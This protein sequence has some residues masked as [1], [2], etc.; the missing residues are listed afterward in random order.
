MKKSILIIAAFVALAMLASCQKEQF[1]ANVTPV[2]GV[3]E[4]T[5]T[6]E[7]PTK[8]AID[9]EGKVSWKA[10]DEIT[11]TDA[12]SNSAVYVAGADGAST[13]FTLKTGETAVG[14]GPYTATYGDI[15]NQIYSAEGANYPLAA[16]ATSTTAF[17][18]SSSYAVVKITAKSEGDEV[19]ESVDVNYGENVYAL[20]CGDGVTL[21][22][23]G[24]DFFVAVETATEAAALSVTF[25][26]ADKTAT[27][28]RTSAVTLA[29]K[30]L[31][32]V[33]LTFAEGDWESPEADTPEPLKGVFTVSDSDTPDDP[34]DD[35]KVSFSQGNLRYV[36][37]TKKWGFYEHQYDFC[38]TV[39]YTGHHSDTV[40]LFTWGYNA[41]QSILPDGAANNNVSRTSGDLEQTEDWGSQIGDGNTWRTLSAAEWMYLSS[42]RGASTVS[43][44]SNARYATA[45]VNGI[46]G[47]ILLPDIY[48]HP[49]EV[50]A[51]S[52]INT[53]SAAFTDNTYD[54]TAWKAMESAGAVF[55]PA[56]GLRGTKNIINDYGIWGFYWSSSAENGD[57]AYRGVNFGSNNYV[58]F[59]TA[60]QYSTRGSGLSVR[61]VT[62]VSAPEP[63]EPEEP[64]EI[65]ITRGK[66]GERAY[67][68]IGKVKWATQNLAI[69]ES[70]NMKW[71]GARTGEN[72]EA[73]KV[74]GTDEDVIVGDY[75]QWAAYAGYC[76]SEDGSDKGLLIYNSFTHDCCVGGDTKREFS[77]KAVNSNDWPPFYFFETKK[78]DSG[79]T[80]K[81]KSPYYIMG[82]GYQKYNN[83]PADSYADNKTVLDSDDDV[84]NILWGNTWRMPTN[85]EFQSLY[86]ATFWAWDATDMGYY[87]FLPA[88]ADQIK[89]GASGTIGSLDKSKA[90]LF[91]PCSGSGSNT[92]LSDNGYYWH[93]TLHD[94][95]NAK[96]MSLNSIRVEF[97]SL[98]RYCGCSVRPVSN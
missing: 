88:D 14:E 49:S 53:P 21:T 66:I 10:G 9:A 71:K 2:A 82:T 86:N 91:F 87:V 23:D 35:V 92:T 37:K 11:V 67:I 77:F 81:G 36:V 96:Y 51:L 30:D 85:E 50:A 19:I 60:S 64:E 6:I 52:K 22:S 57:N 79:G 61:L 63:T 47:I 41:E 44:T 29:A 7:Q 33:T 26:T 12:A 39:T 31:L 43:G 45:T 25:H 74:P 58:Y 4:F 20:N 32:P 93:S 13:T 59:G 75:F 40:S 78:E 56:A 95:S 55:L 15:A 28:E 76:G 27:K 46:A 3:T 24:I 5:A 38:N 70:G 68:G 98:R 62:V 84:A 94:T 34:S 97:S 73:V 72:P 69:S 1:K 42:T 54:L 80:H 65:E 16:P 8:T 90:L 18:F 83:S 17:K 89:G 48:E